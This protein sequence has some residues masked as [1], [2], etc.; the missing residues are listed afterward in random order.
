MTRVLK[1]NIVPK[2]ISNNSNIITSN[3]YNNIDNYEEIQF[4]NEYSGK[5]GYVASNKTKSILPLLM[6]IDIPDNIRYGADN[7]YNKMNPQIRRSNKYS[8]LLY[9]CTHCAYLEFIHEQRTL[10]EKGIIPD[11]KG[12]IIGFDPIQLGKKF[13]L[14]YSQ[15][16]KCDSLYSPLQT[17]YKP[18]SS[19]LSIY[20]Y[21]PN[22]CKCIGLSNESIL[23]VIELS[24]SLIKKDRKLYQENA[25]SIA[26]GILYYFTLI[27]GITITNLPELEQLANYSFSTIKNVC[28]RIAIVDNL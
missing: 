4:G 9:Y 2:G 10:I 21:L 14:E 11:L 16:Q 8:M 23:E 26:A 12:Y 7:I 24:K 18:P 28:D 1:L 3:N 20:D 15:L 27:N 19:Y 13:G 25:R 5:E 17:G 6:K 22:Y